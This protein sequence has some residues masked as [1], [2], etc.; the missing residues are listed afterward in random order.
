[1]TE[2]VGRREDGDLIRHLDQ[3][4]THQTSLTHDCDTNVHVNTLGNKEKP[5]VEPSVAETLLIGA[6]NRGR[7]QKMILFEVETNPDWI[8]F[9][10]VLL[11]I[12][13][14]GWK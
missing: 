13:S 7:L 9:A 2:T 10:P 5:L 6:S 1:M 3:R 12:N 8:S 4:E 14:V 11:L